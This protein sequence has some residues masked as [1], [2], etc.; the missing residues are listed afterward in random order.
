MTGNPETTHFGLTRVGSGEPLSKNGYAALDSDPVRI[1][2][3]LWALMNHD[4]SG[5]PAL[6]DPTDPPTLTVSAS[7]GSLP[8]G[9]TLYYRVSYVDENNLE[10]AGSPE[11]SVTT[12]DFIATPTGPALGVIISGGSLGTGN[13]SYAITFVDAQGGET[14]GSP[15]SSVAVTSG[16]SNSI[17]L[18]LPSLP[19]YAVSYNIY[20]T[21]PGQSELYYLTNVTAGPYTDV[22]IAEDQSITVPA[23]NTTNSANS[24]TV[25][26]PLAFVPDGCQSWRIYRATTSNGYDG[27]SLVHQV[28]ETASDTTATPITTWVDTGDALLPGFPQETTSTV[29]EGHILDLTQITGSLPLTSLPR[30]GQSISVFAPGTITNSQTLLVTEAPGAVKPVRFTAFFSTAPTTGT[31]RLRFA[32]TATN[33]VEL[34]CTHISGDPTGYYRAEFPLLEKA[35]FEAETGT[36]SGAAIIDNDAAASSGQAVSLLDNADYVQVPLGT[37]DPGT[38]DTFVKL[39]VLAFDTAAPGADVTISV[40]DLSTN[41]VVGTPVTLTITS[42]N[43]T[44]PTSVPADYMYTEHAGPIVTLPAGSYALRVAKSTASTQS[45]DVDYMRYQAQLPTLVAGRITATAYVDSGPTDAANLN[46]VLWF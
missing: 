44:D 19:A 36:R 33:Y 46:M 28:V 9:T 20:R 4:H 6:G 23:E 27:E 2:S 40:Y 41:T 29:P 21:R 14:D 5:T 25:E 32:D 34:T 42:S 31:V 16:A 30:G 17:Q 13:Y 35:S 22:G 15:I 24:I 26:I 8:A 11:A 7:G 39:R 1:D 18:T 3:L 43:P 38:Y 12:I 37:L 10:T 45:Y